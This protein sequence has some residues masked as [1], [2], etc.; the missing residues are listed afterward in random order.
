MKKNVVKPKAAPKAADGLDAED[1][2]KADY[3]E[4]L[5]K[6][7]KE[8][9]AK[10]HKQKTDLKIKKAEQNNGFKKLTRQAKDKVVSDAADE[11]QRVIEEQEMKEAKAALENSST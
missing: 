10:I 1:K 5:E 2:K 9:F 3:L 7:L 4:D 8:A 6:N 11:A